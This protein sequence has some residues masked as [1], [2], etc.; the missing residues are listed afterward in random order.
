MAPTSTK[1]PF[2]HRLRRGLISEYIAITDHSKNLKIAS[3]ISE[4]QL[5][6]QAI[7]IGEV[8]ARLQAEGHTVYG[9]R[10]IE[11]DVDSSGEG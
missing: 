2:K 9:L 5:Q 6:Q 7:E 1:W 8:N 10:S 11:L 4:D 3:G